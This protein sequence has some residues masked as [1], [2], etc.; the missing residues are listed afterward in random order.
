MPSL[1]RDLRKSVVIA[2]IERALECANDQ[3]DLEDIW[4]DLCDGF[5]DD[6][7]ERK[8]LLSVYL[9]MTKRFKDAALMVKLLGA[10]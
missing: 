1:K 6:S 2:P 8:Q 3:A 9:R 4:F 7:A 5:A 10:G